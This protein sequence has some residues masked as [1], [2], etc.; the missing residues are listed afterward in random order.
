MSQNVALKTLVARYFADLRMNNWSPRT[1]DR[2]GYSLGRFL[3]WCDDR[4]VDT[5]DGFTPELLEAYRRSLFHHRN[6]RTDKPIKFATQASYLTAVKHWLGWLV[7]QNWLEMNPAENLQ[8]PKAE[9]R[10]PSNHLTLEE[11]ETLLGVVDLTTASGLRDR[12]ILETFY[13]TG[14]RR[15]ELI[16]LHLDDIDHQRGLVVIRQGKGRKDRVVPIGPRALEWLNK[17]LIDGRPV[18]IEEETD[19]LF[20]TTRGNAFH[21]VNLTSLVRSYL[22]AV[23]ITKRGS[24]HMLRHTTATLMLEGGA[25]LRS[26][27]TLLGHENLNT[28]QIYTH[29]TIQRLREVH[30]K[31]HPGAKDPKPAENDEQR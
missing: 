22:D 4:G 2:R 23:G 9:H 13:S 12:A 3:T 31:T 19:V 27:Q 30:D 24:C 1:I 18:L 25:D 15:S 29:V 21:P 16:A 14:M 7:E 28:T 6:P 20:L 26:I 5:V 11:I 10:L 17:Y 8:L